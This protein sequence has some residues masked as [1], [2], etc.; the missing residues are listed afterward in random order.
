MED[1][2][3]I[4]IEKY[5]CT[6]KLLGQAEM[7]VVKRKGWLLLALPLQRSLAMKVLLLYQPQKWRG[8]LLVRFLYLSILFGVYRLGPKLRVRV[9]DNGLMGSFQSGLKLKPFGFL[10][11]SVDSKH[12]SMSAVTIVNDEPV[13]IKGG[14]A[15]AAK[16]IDQEYSNLDV[17]A[18]RSKYALKPIDHGRFSEG[19]YYVTKHIMGASPR[20]ELQHTKSQEI[21][22]GWLIKAPKVLLGEIQP[23]NQML[24]SYGV[25]EEVRK[26]FLKLNVSEVIAP[27][28][29]GDFVPWN[30]K[31][32]ESGDFHIMDWESAVEIQVPT[33]DMWHYWIQQWTLID[34]YTAL[35]VCAQISKWLENEGFI[36]YMEDAGCEGLSRELLGGYLYYSGYVQGYERSELI[37]EWEKNF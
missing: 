23:W 13:V 37:A 1:Q 8:R 19:Y 20:S 36:R 34:E 32:D 7:V 17:F 12:R 4:L 9:G 14:V 2:D 3:I 28:G 10:L 33:W 15:E 26:Y 21:L 16:S 35:E 31:I 29:H 25:S 6:G 27:V 18:T 11:G 24:D 30:I 22:K 5:L